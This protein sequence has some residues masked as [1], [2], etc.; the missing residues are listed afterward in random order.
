MQ[1]LNPKGIFFDLV[2]T[3]VIHDTS[4]WSLF[5]G[6]LRDCLAPKGLAL[7]PTALEMQCERYFQGVT[8]PDD[9]F[10]LT[11]FERRIKSFCND[12]RLAVTGT[13]VKKTATH[14]IGVSRKHLSL[15]PDC[16]HVLE[17]LKRNKKLALVSNYDHPPAIS[18]LIADMKIEEYF[19]AIVISGE[20]GCQK[21]NPAIFNLA[22]QKTGLSA[23]QVL[24]VGDSDDD[25]NG[26]ILSGILPVRIMRTGSSFS[27][28]PTKI[29]G[30][31]II[32]EL[33]TL[34][35]LVD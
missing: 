22:L 35:E 12:A 21:P 27:D 8:P 15:V 9:G 10:G 7:S 33:R 34:L 4:P 32:K 2:D 19:S 30:V 20:V 11:V 3:L 24:H 26:A 16:H 13:D 29:P 18:Q 14:I 6:T 17:T 1:R 5:I 25:I 23:G 28:M 31:K